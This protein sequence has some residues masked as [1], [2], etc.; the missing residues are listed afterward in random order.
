MVHDVSQPTAKSEHKDALRGNQGGEYGG[1]L[2]TTT[3]VSQY[4]KEDFHLC[5]FWGG[6]TVVFTGMN[7]DK[8]KSLI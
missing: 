2:N 1:A 5:C 8:I 6:S 3:H 4:K 7:N